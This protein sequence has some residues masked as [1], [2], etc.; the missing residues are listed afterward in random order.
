MPNIVEIT[1]LCIMHG[2]HTSI[3]KRGLV[4]LKYKE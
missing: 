4:F 2:V 1:H 3:D